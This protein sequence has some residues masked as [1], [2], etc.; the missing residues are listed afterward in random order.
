MA[1]SRTDS[2]SRIGDAALQN[3]DAIVGLLGRAKREGSPR[4]LPIN[5]RDNTADPKAITKSGMKRRILQLDQK[6]E[7]SPVE[8]SQLAERTIWFIAM[9][10]FG[11]V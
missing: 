4:K 1:T 2:A 10:L 3:M 6:G 11:H 9:L 5:Q 8:A 7:A